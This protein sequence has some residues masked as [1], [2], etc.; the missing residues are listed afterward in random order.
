ERAAIEASMQA[1]VLG[2]QSS[3]TLMVILLCLALIPAVFT[4]RNPPPV[5]TPDTDST[6]EAGGAKETTDP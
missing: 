1:Q 3:F 2:F 6:P 5:P 4:L